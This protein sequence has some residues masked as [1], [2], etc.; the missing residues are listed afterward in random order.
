[1]HFVVLQGSD[2]PAVAAAAPNQNALQNVVCLFTKE[3]ERFLFHEKFELPEI[4]KDEWNGIFG[5]SGKEDSL[6][7]YSEIFA[8]F[9]PG[10]T[11]PFDF[12]P[13]ILEVSG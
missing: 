10:I 8:N 2:S 11:V 13:R 4:S 7:R 5:I 1:M 9:L 6:A 12:S 3:N